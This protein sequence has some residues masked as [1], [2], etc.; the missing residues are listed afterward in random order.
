MVLVS[1]FRMGKSLPV[2]V[3]ILC[4]SQFD[5]EI[6]VTVGNRHLPPDRQLHEP[7][8]RTKIQ[9]FGATTRERDH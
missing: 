5:G 9:G 2:H 7:I 1:Q 6:M 4:D 3:F 8:P